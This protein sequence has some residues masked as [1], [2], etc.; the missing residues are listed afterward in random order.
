MNIPEKIY[1]HKQTFNFRGKNIKTLT[2]IHFP[3]REYQYS[4]APLTDN[5]L[6]NLKSNTISCTKHQKHIATIVLSRKEKKASIELLVVPKKR[7]GER[8]NKTEECESRLKYIFSG[9][10]F[11]RCVCCEYLIYMQLVKTRIF[12]IFYFC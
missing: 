5:Y 1:R 4:V 6:N 3:R 9:V 10:K 8:G 11:C 12:L 7:A 2:N